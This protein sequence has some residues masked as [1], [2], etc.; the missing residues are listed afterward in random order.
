[1]LEN[2]ATLACA[3]RPVAA[4]AV[5]APVAHPSLPLG[6]TPREPSRRIRTGW[7]TAGW[8]GIALAAVSGA[9]GAYLMLAQTAD[10]DACGFDGTCKSRVGAGASIPGIVLV[11]LGV[12]GLVFG[13]SALLFDGIPGR[14]SQRPKISLG[15]TPGGVQVSGSF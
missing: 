7:T 13:G 1:L 4:R 12:A 9:A 5:S 15:M 3:D 8:V 14:R 10:Y 6:P 2:E 11:D